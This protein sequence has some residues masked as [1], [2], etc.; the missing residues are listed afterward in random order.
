MK[1]H[2]EIPEHYSSFISSHPSLRDTTRIG[3][4][5]RGGWVKDIFTGLS[6]QQMN[7]TKETEIQIKPALPRGKYYFLFSIN[8]GDYNPTHNSEKIMLEI[9]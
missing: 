6:L 9:L 7:K 2:F 8:S 4:F 1:C 3:I 5:D